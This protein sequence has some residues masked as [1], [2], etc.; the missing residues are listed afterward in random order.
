MHN[1]KDVLQYLH[2]S[3]NVLSKISKTQREEKF[4][5]KNLNIKLKDTFNNST[6]FKQLKENVG[7]IKF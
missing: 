1:L 2:D 6:S 4:D 7:V 5:N 3:R